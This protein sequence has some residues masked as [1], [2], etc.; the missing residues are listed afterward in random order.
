MNSLKLANLVEFLS[1]NV[2]AKIF[3]MQA[4]IVFIKIII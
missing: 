4:Q 2:K 3:G 1:L